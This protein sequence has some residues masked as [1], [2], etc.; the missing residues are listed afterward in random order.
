MCGREILIEGFTQHEIL[1]LP[2]ETIDGLILLGGPLVFRA[3]SATILGSFKINSGRLVIEL[4]QI[5]GGG[6]GVLVTLS[7]LARRYA[8]LRGLRSV[9]WVVH[10]INCATP[11][12]KLRKMLERRGF[13]IENV[14][15]VGAAYHLLDDLSL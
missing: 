1:R 2:A 4:A 9:E 12:L 6:E 13:V 14:P 5:E 3:G 8:A 11:N 15:E 10:A 7:S